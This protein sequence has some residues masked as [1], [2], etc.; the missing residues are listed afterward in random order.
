[1]SDEIALRIEIEAL[2]ADRDD[3]AFKLGAEIARNQELVEQLRL[4][5]IDAMTCE[6]EL[7]EAR[8][9]AQ[10]QADFIFEQAAQIERYQKSIAL[11][12]ANTKRMTAQICALR[13]AL[14]EAVDFAED[15]HGQMQSDYFRDR[16]RPWLE[17]VK[18]KAQA[19]LK[20]EQ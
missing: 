4:A 1:M 16:Y 14:I 19:A 11:T 17:E 15:C 7:N 18:Q 20:G 6:A 3:L 5:N 8:E 2:R 10:K 13:E 9:A 12:D